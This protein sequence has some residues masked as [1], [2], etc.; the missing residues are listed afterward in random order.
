MVAAFLSD[1]VKLDAA[2]ARYVAKMH[3]PAPKPAPVERDFIHV[4]SEPLAPAPSIKRVI[5][6]VATAYG[7]SYGEVVG[8]RRSLHILPAR[9]AA[10]HAV[11]TARPDF[12]LTQIARHFGNRDHTTILSGLRKVRREGIPLPVGRVPSSSTEGAR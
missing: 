8:P 11:A 5:T 3:P 2:R 7:V 9:L 6:E 12:S 10:Y 4:S 1:P